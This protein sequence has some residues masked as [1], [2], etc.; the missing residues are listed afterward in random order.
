MIPC[1]SDLPVLGGE[2]QVE[3]CNA[4]ATDKETAQS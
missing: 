1:P 3:V 4:K 2:F